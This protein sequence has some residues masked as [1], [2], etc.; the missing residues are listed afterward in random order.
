M[1]KWVQHFMR[2][3]AFMLIG[4]LL[5]SP[6]F[7]QA[8]AS[9]PSFEVASVKAVQ[10][11]GGPPAG[12][13][14][15]PRRSGGRVTWTTTLGFL[16]NYAYHLSDWQIVRT[17]KDQ[18]FYAIEAIMDESTSEEQVRLMSRALLAERFKLAA[19]RETKEVQGYAL[20]ATKDE[21][22]IKASAAG[23]THP[24]PDYLGGK[25]SAAFEGR[26]FVSMEGKATSALTGRGVSTAQLAE[27]LSAELGTFVLD[28]TGLSGSYY[29]GFRF[30]SLRGLNDVPE[31]PSLFSAVQDELGLKLEKQKGSP[32]VLVIDHIQQPSEN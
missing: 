11:S 29:F 14:L 23:D 31:A 30:A 20:I 21:P 28:Q 22:K 25:P 19:H 24:M 18:S 8:A 32:E 7:A 2:V 15:S 10:N 9:T 26:I 17:D 4:A 16:L 12:F 5:A 1:Q 13:S 6:L 27:A 3:P